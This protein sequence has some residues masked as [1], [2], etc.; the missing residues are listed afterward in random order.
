MEGNVEMGNYKVLE[1]IISN[2]TGGEKDEE[3]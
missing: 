3:V 2:I 1:K